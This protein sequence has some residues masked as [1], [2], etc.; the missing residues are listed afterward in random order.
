MTGWSLLDMHS[1]K[2]TGNERHCLFYV[3]A[4]G[5]EGTRP[6]LLDQMGFGNCVLVRDSA[7]N[8]DVVADPA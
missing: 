5:V 2:H 6:V 8:S 4:S 1:R 3:L 7:A